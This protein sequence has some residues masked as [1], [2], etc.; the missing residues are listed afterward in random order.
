MAMIKGAHTAEV[1]Q[2]EQELVDA[3]NLIRQLRAEREALTEQ[4]SDDG[5]REQW[6]MRATQSVD[7]RDRATGDC[8]II[9]VR[10]HVEQQ[11]IESER[12]RNEDKQVCADDVSLYTWSR[13]CFYK[14]CLNSF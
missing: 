11:T 8:E 9:V 14:K 10:R 3:E 13:T 1:A 12:T 5:K 6:L 7:R 2:L 4:V